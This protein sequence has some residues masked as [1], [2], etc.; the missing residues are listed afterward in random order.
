MKINAQALAAWNAH[1]V[2]EYPREACGLLVAED[3]RRVY[4][5]CRNIAETPGEHFILAPADYADAEDRGEVVALLH[6][7]PNLPPRASHA[8]RVGCEATGLPWGIVSVG[9]DGIGGSE[10]ITPDGYQAPLIGREFAFGVLDCYALVRDWYARER[11]ITLPDV[12][13][14]DRFWERGEN[15]LLDNFAAAGFAPIRG[16]LQPGDVFIMQIGRDSRGGPAR[17]PNHCGVYLGDDVFL[18]HLHNRLS[19]RDVFG[20]MWAERTVMTVRYAGAKEALP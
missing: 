12:E 3:G 11:G 20:G 8:D 9:V 16:G 15:L 19:G 4:V 6:S 1:A 18:H 13:R 10:W 17:L 7:H 2:T 5:P 14:R